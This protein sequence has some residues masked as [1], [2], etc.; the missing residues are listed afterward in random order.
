MQANPV[1]LRRCA[2][3]LRPDNIAELY[4]IARAH[5]G[6]KLVLRILTDDSKARVRLG[7][8]FGAPLAI[9]P[10]LLEKAKELSLDVVGVSFHV[11]SECSDSDA[12]VGAVHRARLAFDM[13]AE[14]GYTFKLL[15]VGGGFENTTFEAAASGIMG[16]LDKWFPNRTGAGSVVAERG[17]SVRV[18]AEPGRFYVSQAFKLAVSIIGKR[19]VEAGPDGDGNDSHR[20]ARTENTKMD[21]LLVGGTNKGSPHLMCESKFFLAQM[22]LRYYSSLIDYISD[23]V[24]GVLNCV[25]LNIVSVRP[26]ILSMSGSSKTTV[27]VPLQ[28]CIVWEP[29]CDSGDCVF[30]M[31]QLPETLN[32][33]DWLAFD[34]MGAYT[35]SLV[36][37]FNGFE[38]G[39]I[40][41]TMGDVY[42]LEVH[43]VLTAFAATHITSTCSSSCQ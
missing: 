19:T 34:N 39:N 7:L 4:K 13:G 43:A 33:G 42:S 3:Q 2:R 32:V 31:L 24:H 17:N 37:H 27:M 29:T 36:G 20:E 25:G 12:F 23:G 28:P 6:A 15:D 18:I 14:A 11:G 22:F 10:A 5:R 41:Y 1:H 30:P 8:K 21:G 16:A 38:V 9:V 40:L 35:I 26:Y